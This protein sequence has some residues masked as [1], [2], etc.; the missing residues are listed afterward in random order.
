MGMIPCLMLANN[1]FFLKI[2]YCNSGDNA[3][4]KAL[5]SV[6]KGKEPANIP[7]TTAIDEIYELTDEPSSELPTEKVTPARGAKPDIQSRFG[8]IALCWW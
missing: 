3:S 5:P 6:P 1:W 4:K 2:Y 8:T 7:A